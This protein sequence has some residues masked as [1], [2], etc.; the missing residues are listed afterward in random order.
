MLIF[1]RKIRRRAVLFFILLLLVGAGIGAAESLKK[2]YDSGKRLS[3]L[4]DELAAIRTKYSSGRYEE[5]V[6]AISGLGSERHVDD[7]AAR[8]EIQ[9]PGDGGW[10]R[11]VD[12]LYGRAELE[13][14]VDKSA[15]DLVSAQQVKSNEPSISWPDINLLG[16]TYSTNS[17]NMK[18]VTVMSVGGK[19]EIWSWQKKGGEYVSDSMIPGF[20][21][22]SVEVSR[23]KLLFSLHPIERIEMFKKYEMNTSPDKELSKYAV[24]DP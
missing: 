7:E 21:I 5:T 11:A 10:R 24:Q 22:R 9:F 8:F 14:L 20:D 23:D 18:L 17:K 19:T 1:F 16:A 4:K 15:A 3:S 12:V 13:T 2:S 6:K